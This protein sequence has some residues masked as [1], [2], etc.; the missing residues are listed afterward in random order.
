MTQARLSVTP[1]ANVG[2]VVDPDTDARHPSGTGGAGKVAKGWLSETEPQ[3]WENW[4]INRSQNKM[5]NRVV[6]GVHQIDD[7]VTYKSNSLVWDTNGKIYHAKSAN[8]NKP[9]TDATVWEEAISYSKD[10]WLAI[11]NKMASDLAT[12]TTANVIKHG[13]TIGQAGGKTASAIDSQ[14]AAVRVTL[15]SHVGAHYPHHETAAQVGTIHYTGGTFEGQIGYNAGFSM[16]DYDEVTVNTQA[17]IVG[18]GTPD[19]AAFGVGYPNFREGGRIQELVSTARFPD[20]ET[21][22]N[23]IF[24]CPAADIIIPLVA[25]L[26]TL[27]CGFNLTLSRPNTL[28][29][30][31]KAGVAQVAAVNVAAFEAK[32]LKMD[33]NTSLSISNWPWKTIDMATI[34]FYLNGVRQVL[35]MQFNPTTYPL[36]WIFGNTG[37]IRDVRIWFTKLTD[38]QLSTLA[39]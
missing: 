17:E 2:F 5:L 4:W 3:Q 8:T 15:D 9:T 29:Y 26:T 12:H 20:M 1:W 16:S 30:T 39:A 36:Q 31:D 6:S 28:A 37:N 23:P 21:D 19:G 33:A 7:K 25:N 27:T 38:K 18:M 35:F 22:Y 13:E 24:A 14:I 34:V 10:A 11:T 32:G